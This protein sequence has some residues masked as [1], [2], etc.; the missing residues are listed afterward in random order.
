MEFIQN[1]EEET[2]L[3]LCQ[4]ELICHLKPSNSQTHTYCTAASISNGVQHMPVCEDWMFWAITAAPH[5][6][7]FH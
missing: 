4:T 5:F 7:D 2:A 6:T 1:V 3:E